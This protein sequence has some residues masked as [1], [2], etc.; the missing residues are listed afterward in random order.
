MP[1]NVGILCKYVTTSDFGA[2]LLTAPQVRKERYY[3]KMPFVRWFA[4]NAGTIL[5][6]FPEVKDDNVWIITGTFSAPE[7]ALNAWKEQEKEIVVGFSGTASQTAALEA[8]GIWYT[9]STSD[10][11][12]RYFKQ[13]VETLF[14]FTLIW[15]FRERAT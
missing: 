12:W 9:A 4:R 3:H 7:C 6:Q 15:R 5:K 13:E 2:V 14:V 8:K 10:P 11:G 1:A